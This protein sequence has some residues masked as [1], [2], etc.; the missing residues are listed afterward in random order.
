MNLMSK[1]RAGWSFCLG[2]LARLSTVVGPNGTSVTDNIRTSYGTFLT[3]MQDP[4]VEKIE[5]RLT[6]WTHLPLVHQEDMQDGS[7]RV[8]TVL[9]YL[10]NDTSLVGGETAFPKAPYRKSEDGN[11]AVVPSCAKGAVA[12]RPRKGDAL[13]FYSLT[14][15]GQQDIY[16]MHQGCP[17]V[18]GV[19]WTATKWI[20]TAP[21]HPEWLEKGGEKAIP[22]WLRLPDGCEDFDSNCKGWSESGECEKNHGYMAGDDVSLGQ[23][24]LSCKAC[25]NCAPGDRACGNR[26]RERGGFLVTPDGTD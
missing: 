18:Q 11:S 15:T 2:S 12:M 19:K 16:S 23:C 14:P 13:L 22:R 21:F 10:N 20:D 4:I 26:N 1:Q 24:R 9:L 17:V 6:A 3:R 7:A 5:N 8:A 25:E